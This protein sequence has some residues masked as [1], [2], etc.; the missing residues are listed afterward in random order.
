MKLS[1]GLFSF[2]IMLVQAV[3][4]SAQTLPADPV[5]ARQLLDEMAVMLNSPQMQQQF[6]RLFGDGIK[7]SVTVGDGCMSY[8]Y[9]LPGY[10]VTDKKGAEAI[11]DIFM[12]SNRDDQQKAN[13]MLLLGRLLDVA[14]YDLEYLYCNETG[15][16][17]ARKMTPSRLEELMTLPLADL[18]LDY[19]AALD[20]LLN[21]MNVGMELGQTGM[22]IR[23]GKVHLNGKYIN[24]PFLCEGDDMQA[25]FDA[26]ISDRTLRDILL[27]EMLGMPGMSFFAGAMV[28]IGRA[29]ELHGMKF[30]MRSPSG[31]QKVVNLSWDAIEKYI[32]DPSRTPMTDLYVETVRA[33]IEQSVKGDPSVLSGYVRYKAPYIE[34]MI[35]H[36]ASDLYYINIA[37][38]KAQ[39]LADL[40][41]DKDIGDAARSLIQEGTEGFRYVYV[42]R[43]GTDRKEMLIRCQEII[44]R[45]AA[46]GGI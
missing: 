12:S 17:F 24:M 38:M 35:T 23:G 42:N 8:R 19:R 44:D 39:L 37:E 28:K 15:P 33:E 34:I 29:L 14:G 30:D 16:V 21:Q 13:S 45:T 10:R 43:D 3:T 26:D 41:A 9:V 20:E 31:L 4:A 46:G 2:L 1:I 40:A 6:G 36:D 25:F 22:G 32:S 5:Q 11:T 7:V 18:D 27:S